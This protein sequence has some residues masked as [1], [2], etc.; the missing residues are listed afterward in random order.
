MKEKLRT[1][2]R[3]D[4]ICSSFIEGFTASTML[5]LIANKQNLLMLFGYS[6]I[7]GCLVAYIFGKTQFIEKITRG[8]NI[9]RIIDVAFFYDI[10]MYAVLTVAGIISALTQYM[11]YYVIT[12][13]LYIAISYILQAPRATYKQLRRDLAFDSIEDYSRWTQ[14]LMNSINLSTMIG[15][16]VNLLM[17][18]VIPTYTTLTKVDI[19]YIIFILSIVLYCVDI[20]ISIL[21]YKHITNQRKQV[22]TLK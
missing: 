12:V 1:L 18:N 7:F 20:T 21:E 17:L 16:S 13:L 11:E 10:A 3:M 19:S 9:D 5:L 4:E 2:M 14:S 8:H 6:G 22:A 15:A